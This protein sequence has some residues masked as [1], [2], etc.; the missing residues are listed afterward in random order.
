MSRELRHVPVRCGA[1]SCTRSRDRLGSLPGSELPASRYLTTVPAQHHLVRMG[2]K[3][4]LF[5]DTWM[6][7]DLIPSTNQ[8]PCGRHY[9]VY[10]TWK[11]P[12]HI[13]RTI[14]DD[15]K[16]VFLVKEDN[17]FH[18]VGKILNYLHLKDSLKYKCEMNLKQPL[19]SPQH[20][21]LV[22][23]HTS[24]RRLAIEIGRWSTIP[25]SRSRY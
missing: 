12:N 1:P 11:H 18:H 15:I 24:N 17:S 2:P 19:T 5:H 7:K 25:I 14:Y 20:K 8:K 9:G 21:V 10:L 3:Q 22:A 23:Y 16:E 6:N 13:K 4:P